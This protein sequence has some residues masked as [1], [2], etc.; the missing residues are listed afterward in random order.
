MLD[1]GTIAHTNGINLSA[2]ATQTFNMMEFS[3]RGTQDSINV[4]KV[5]NDKSM[6]SPKKHGEDRTMSP[7]GGVGTAVNNLQVKSYNQTFKKFNANY[8]ELFDLVHD[9]SNSERRCK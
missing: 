8:A 5:I 4:E 1:V 9:Y 2:M 7:T 6:I 3:L